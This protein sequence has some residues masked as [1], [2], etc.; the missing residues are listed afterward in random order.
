MNKMTEIDQA[1]QAEAVSWM[2]AEYLISLPSAEAAGE[3]GAFES[4][5]QPGE[6]P[7][8]HVHIDHDEI[9]HVIEGELELYM[10]G[11]VC[12]RRAG[13][14]IFLPRNVAHTFRVV[15]AGPARCLAVVAPGG[16]EEFFPAAAAA[17]VGPADMPALAALAAR[18]KLEFVG[19][20]PLQP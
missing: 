8:L 13:E 4:K 19:P 17:G 2:G 10:A 7:P 14:S 15:S 1:P 12:R 18:F 20:S 6:G 5:V 3:I 9:I 16:F 11:A